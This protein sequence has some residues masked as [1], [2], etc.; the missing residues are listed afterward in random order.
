MNDY[1]FTGYSLDLGVDA[2][3]YTHA[4]FWAASEFFF[5]FLIIVS[6]VM[7]SIQSP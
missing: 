4:L 5:F 7:Q 1:S 2:N 6:M 3:W